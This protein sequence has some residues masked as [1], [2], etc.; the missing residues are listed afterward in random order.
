MKITIYGTGCPKCKKL[1]ET[2][3][4]AAA[5]LNISCEINKVQDINEIVSAGV[6]S[7]PALGIDGKIV[8]SGRIPT[9]EGM[10]D[11]LKKAE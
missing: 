3:E 5:E 10:K 9:I 11:I 7:T 1:H 2:A 6:M 8:L 4:K